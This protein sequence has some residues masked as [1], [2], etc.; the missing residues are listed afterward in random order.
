[1]VAIV[2]K[3]NGYLLIT[4]SIC[5]YKREKFDLNLTISKYI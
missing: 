1:L 2:S 4:K 3:S 5:L